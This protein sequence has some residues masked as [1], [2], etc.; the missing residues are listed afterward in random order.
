MKGVKGGTMRGLLLHIMLPLIVGALSLWVAVYGYEP[1]Q[2]IY[3]EAFS[4]EQRQDKETYT[5]THIQPLGLFIPYVLGIGGVALIGGSVYMVY[6]F[7]NERNSKA[8]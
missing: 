1:I 2:L 3:Q 5:I 4:E 6:K 7:R 8:N